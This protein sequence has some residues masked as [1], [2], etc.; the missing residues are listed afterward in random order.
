MTWVAIT[1]DTVLDDTAGTDP[2]EPMKYVAS[3]SF[4]K[5]SLAMVLNLIERKYPLD[6]VVF[7]NTGVEFQAIYDIRDKMI[8][9]FEEHGITF[10]ELKPKYPFEYMMFDK[11]VKYRDGSGI[12][13]GYSWCGGQNRWGTGEKIQTILKYSKNAYQYV[14]IAYDEPHRFEKSKHEL[15]LTPLVEWQMTEADC[16]KYCYDH[17]FYWE[18][19]GVR[20]YDILDRVSCW[21]CANKNR[22]EL[23]NIYQYMPE[24][25]KRLKDFQSRT[26][27]PMKQYR[28]RKYGDYGNVFDMEKVFEQEKE[29]V[30]NAES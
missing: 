16:L 15:K 8:P 10:T 17:G 7:Y 5:D 18:E 3:C 2:G 28:N 9:I 11:P 26:D 14:G 13:Y 25:W 1:E 22:R 20:L 4:G 12:H 27:R 6:E 29:D 23:K 21:C 30:E 19:N 24:Y